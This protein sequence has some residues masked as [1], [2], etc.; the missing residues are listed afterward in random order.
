[1]TRELET[2]IHQRDDTN[3]AVSGS[4]VTSMAVNGS[5]IKSPAQNLTSRKHDQKTT[6]TRI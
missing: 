3:V 1:M 2:D 6:G 5:E 4:E